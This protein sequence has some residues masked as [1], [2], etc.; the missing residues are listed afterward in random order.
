MIR[1]TRWLWHTLCHVTIIHYLIKCS[2]IKFASIAVD[3]V[4]NLG[5]IPVQSNGSDGFSLFVFK[6]GTSWVQ[7][8]DP[9]Q[10]L[11]L[12]SFNVILASISSHVRAQ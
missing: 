2:A 12:M 6:H 10:L 8:S 3:D 1:N 4:D 9:R 11:A 7:S 5:I